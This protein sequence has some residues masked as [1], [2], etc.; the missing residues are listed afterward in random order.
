[1]PST[2]TGRLKKGI[3]GIGPSETR[4]P[5]CALYGGISKRLGILEGKGDRGVVT[6]KKVVY[7]PRMAQMQSQIPKTRSGSFRKKRHAFRLHG[8]QAA[9]YADRRNEWRQ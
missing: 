2:L 4:M 9:V 6:V 8:R 1:M 5:E 3:K 7:F